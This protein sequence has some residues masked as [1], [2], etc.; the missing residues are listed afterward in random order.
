MGH[1]NG[2][3]VFLNLLIPERD[4]AQKLIITHCFSHVLALVCKHS[5]DGV[6]YLTRH[7]EPLMLRLWICISKVSG[8]RPPI[9]III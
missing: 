1:L 2:L 5:S 4:F 8:D 6:P 9:I 7:F 3:V